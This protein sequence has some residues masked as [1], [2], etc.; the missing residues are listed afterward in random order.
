MKVTKFLEIVEAPSGVNFEVKDETVTVT[1]P[2]GNVTKRLS[3]PGVV[4][5]KDGNKVVL[6]VDE[7]TKN[8]KRLLFTFLAHINN[9]VRGVQKPYVYKLKVLS[10]HF[11]MTVT[12]SGEIFSV[13]NYLGEKVPRTMKVKKGATVK[14]E[15]QMITVEGADKD[16][17]SQI[18]AD[19][20]Q[21]MRITNRDRRVFQDGIYLVE[22]DGQAI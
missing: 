4:I 17:V 16:L 19:I 20:E 21:L 1:G 15:G 7:A 10:G 6:Q 11:P 13:K 8:K 18:S 12:V 3:W 2:K 5:K 9:M 14:V 22:K